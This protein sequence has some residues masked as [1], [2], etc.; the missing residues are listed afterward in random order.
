M[1]L[2]IAGFVLGAIAGALAARR[3]GGGRAD[4]AQWAAAWGIVLAVAGVVVTVTL[5]RSGG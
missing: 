4:M 3:R 1:I 5:L 2:P